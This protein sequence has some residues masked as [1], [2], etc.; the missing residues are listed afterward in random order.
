MRKTKQK[1]LRK[2]GWRI[3]DAKD[4]LGLSHDEVRILEV[5][6]VLSVHSS[7]QQAE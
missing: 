4:L 2:L 3:G 6:L 5:K 1:K 7:Q